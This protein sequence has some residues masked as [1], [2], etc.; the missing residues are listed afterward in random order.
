MMIYGRDYTGDQSPKWQKNLER[1]I[2][3]TAL[4]LLG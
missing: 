4:A 2:R 1:G 3:L